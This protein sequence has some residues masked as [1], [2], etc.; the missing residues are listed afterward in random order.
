MAIKVAGQLLSRMPGEMGGEIR[1]L[2]YRLYEICDSKGWAEHA[3]Y[4]NDLV[5]RWPQISDEALRHK[6][7]PEQSALM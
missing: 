1:D 6:Q 7:Q 2:A 4:Y 3:F 5:V